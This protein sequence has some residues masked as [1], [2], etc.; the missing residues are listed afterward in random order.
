SAVI[1]V[2]AATKNALLP[3]SAPASRGRFSR[4]LKNRTIIDDDGSPPDP[5]IPTVSRSVAP[6]RITV[7]QTA[8]RVVGHDSSPA[9]NAET[10]W[11]MFPEET[12]ISICTSTRATTTIRSTR[13]HRD[14]IA[15]AMHHSLSSIVPALPVNAVEISIHEIVDMVF[16]K[17]TSRLSTIS[18]A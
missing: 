7:S 14:V 8:T 2:I 18:P 10:A 1:V 16:A 4:P 17:Y 3:V 9:T 6:V 11:R 12:D 15:L 13:P 5:R